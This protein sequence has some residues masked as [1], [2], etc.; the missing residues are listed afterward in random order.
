MI[1]RFLLES[2]RREASRSENGT[3][4]LRIAL[5]IF[6]DLGKTPEMACS[7]GFVLG[8]YGSFGLAPSS[9]YGSIGLG[10]DSAR[11]SIGL[12]PNVAATKYIIVNI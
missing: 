9:A 4:R 10:P 11:G 8:K 12:A 5:R 2:A 6:L 7:G 3:I 1:R